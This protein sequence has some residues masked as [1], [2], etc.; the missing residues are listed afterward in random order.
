[1]EKILTYIP[2]IIIGFLLIY[3]IGILIQAWILQITTH[4]FKVPNPS[5]KISLGTTLIGYI[6]S[7]LLMVIINC[8]LFVFGQ[9]SDLEKVSEWN[10]LAQLGSI[11]AST[12]LI[13]Y[14]YSIGKG[15]AFF[16]TLS[17]LVIQTI[18]FTIILFFIIFTLVAIVA[19]LGFLPTKG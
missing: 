2:Y 3:V 5:W 16:I 4:L 14:Y 11:A 13:S 19:S 17:V 7:L 8:L 15:K 6:G 12:W 9:F 10:R 18:I 1:M